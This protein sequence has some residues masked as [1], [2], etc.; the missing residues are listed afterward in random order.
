MT[1]V[2]IPLDMWEEDREGVIVSWIYRTGAT[3]TKGEPLCEVMVEKVQ[4]DLLAP[5]SG[6]LTI[7]ED[8]DAIVSK[9]QTI[10]TI[11]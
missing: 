6:L 3:V 11:E 7:V 2:I 4:S 10:A 5:A 8:A 1:D 9:G